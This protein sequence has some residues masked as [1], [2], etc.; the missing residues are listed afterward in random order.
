MRYLIIPSIIVFVLLGACVQKEI[1]DDVSLETGSGYDYVNGKIRGTTLI[2]VYLPDKSVRNKT[3]TAFSQQSRE[4]LLNIQR[5]SSDPIVTGSLKVVLFGEKLSKK[6]GILA[7]MDSFQ[8]DPSIGAGLYLA[9]TEGE[10]KKFLAG[11]YGN[12]GNAVYIT[13]LIRHNMKNK[14]VP[15][16]DMQRFLF[17]F[18]QIGKTPYLPR[19]KKIGKEQMEISGISFF[20]YGKIVDSIPAKKMFYFKLLVDKY[21]QGTLNISIDKEQAVVES[22]RSKYKMQLA[23]R[24]PYTVDVKLKVNAV[25]NEYSGKKVTPKDIKKIEKK[26]QKNI[27][28]ECRDLV[29]E[30]KEKNIDPVGFGHFIKSKT[31]NFSFENWKTDYQYLKVNVHAD[32]TIMESGVIE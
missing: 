12:R 27:E 10:S 19:L 32:V 23:S 21:S 30:F 22:I 5:Q 31:R 8:R 16:T 13:N 29:T 25:L 4:F 17:D 20:R 11:D 7:L 1:L 14:D 26:L 2:P 24:N 18:N 6:E 28:F 3:F 9:V 15:K